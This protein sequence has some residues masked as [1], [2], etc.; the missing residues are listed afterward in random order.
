MTSA[1]QLLYR[2]L[3]LPPR[4]DCEPATGLWLWRGP[5]PLRLRCRVSTAGPG[6][7]QLVTVMR[8]HDG[9]GD[10]RGQARFGWAR[11]GEARQGKSG[12][13]VMDE[14]VTV[15][16]S[17]FSEARRDWA[18]LG[19]FRHGPAGRCVVSQGAWCAVKRTPCAVWGEASHG[20]ARLGMASRGSARPGKA[21][22]FV[23][24]SQLEVGT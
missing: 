8:G 22:S 12:I 5:N 4:D 13:T 23:L 21:S 1:T 2:H 3:G 19:S 15:S 6:L 10:F 11:P 18:G 14:T 24:V 16:H 7:P 17:G 9:G 20:P